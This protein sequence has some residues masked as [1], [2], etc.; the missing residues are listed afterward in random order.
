MLIVLGA[1]LAALIALYH[2]RRSF[3]YSRDILERVRKLQDDNRRSSE[4]VMD[5]MDRIRDVSDRARE[6]MDRSASLADRLRDVLVRTE[7]LPAGAVPPAGVM[8]VAER[9]AARSWDALVTLRYVEAIKLLGSANR[10]ERLGGIYA[11]E[12]IMRESEEDHA[13]VVQ[14]LAAHVRHEAPAPGPEEAV[15]MAHEHVQAALTVIGRRPGR[16]ERFSIDLART[17]LRGAFLVDARLDGALLDSARLERANMVGARLG[18]AFLVG[19]ALDGAFLVDARLEGAHLVGARLERAHLVGARL[20]RAVLAGAFL[21]RALLAGARLNGAHLEGADLR[22]ADLDGADLSQAVGLRAEQLA[23]AVLLPSTRLPDE[24]AGDERVM[25][26][27]AECG[28][29]RGMMTP[30][31]DGRAVAA[32]E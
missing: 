4:R 28:R 23:A 31:V 25:A 18:R 7:D 9:G 1:G 22:N 14:V 6:L 5:L 21:E 10:T 12:R 2:A 29:L 17:D 3:R 20:D 16:E 26:R 15:D 30:L 27:V 8:T 24:L 32:L 19:A 13:A 11:L